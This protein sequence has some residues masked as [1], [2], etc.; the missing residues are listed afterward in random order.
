MPFGR[1]RPIAS[2]FR[3]RAEPSGRARSQR[4]ARKGHRAAKPR[5]APRNRR[6]ESA[7]TR[8]VD[9]IGLQASRAGESPRDEAR[10]VLPRR[11]PRARGPGG[12]QRL[13]HGRRQLQ[14]RASEHVPTGL[15]SGSRD[16]H[17]RHLRPG[18]DD[19]DLPDRQRARHVQ[20]DPLPFP[21]CRRRQRAPAGLRQRARRARVDGGAGPHRLRAHPRDRPQ[22]LQR[23]GRA[24]PASRA[25]GARRRPPGP[26]ADLPRARI[27]RRRP[28]LLGT[29]ARRE[30]RPHPNKTNVTARGLPL[31]LREV[32]RLGGLG[33][34]D[35]QVAA[36]AIMWSPA[37]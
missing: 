5:R 37:R 21:A 11:V 23:P 9:D 7:L 17:A 36:G 34:L 33:P 10:P 6:D 19:G 26:H 14:D 15:H 25:R 18:G 31:R 8:L 28:Q 24:A 3:L 16:Q 13:G 1:F 20:R 4:R 2:A 12:R 29:A 30:D 35:D 32:P 22:H 27:R